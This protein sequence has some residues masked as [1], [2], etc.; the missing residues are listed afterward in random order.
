MRPTWIDE[1]SAN[2]VNEVASVNSTLSRSCWFYLLF[3]QTIR[4]MAK[5]FN[6]FVR[7]DDGHSIHVQVDPIRHEINEKMNLIWARQ[8]MAVKDGG[9]FLDSTGRPVTHQPISQRH[10]KEQMTLS[11]LISNSTLCL[12]KMTEIM[13]FDRVPRP[14]WSVTVTWSWIN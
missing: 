3:S 12:W 8:E 14:Y 13:N 6:A 9:H 4:S 10:V 11:Q 2:Y 1:L 5:I 7:G